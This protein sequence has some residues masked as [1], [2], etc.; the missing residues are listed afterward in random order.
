MPEVRTPTR[1][2]VLFVEAW[3][4]RWLAALTTGSP[5][6]PAAEVMQLGL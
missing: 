3:I 5:A 2:W 1:G 6:G 4:D